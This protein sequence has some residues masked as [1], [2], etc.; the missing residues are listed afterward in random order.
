M[1][2]LRQSPGLLSR[3]PLSAQV[4]SEIIRRIFTGQYT[5]GSQLPTENQLARDL[6]VSRS[7]VRSAY[8]YLRARGIITVRHGIG[9]FVLKMPSLANP[10]EQNIEIPEV[11]SALGY[12]IG[13]YQRKAEIISANQE[14]SNLLE[15]ESGSEVLEVYKVFT[16][17]EVPIILYINH[18]PAWIFQDRTRMQEACEP[19]LTEPPDLFLFNFCEIRMKYFNSTIHPEIYCNVEQL[20]FFGY[21]NPNEPIL[22]VDDIGFDDLGRKVFHSV[23]YLTRIAA[24][25]DVN[26]SIISPITR[27]N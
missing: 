9:A 15:I 25:F 23:E 2:D 14:L 24:R 4:E 5:P 19:T 6:G 18:F 20:R 3:Q 26:R 7:T 11:I 21:E 22:I 27:Q 8:S 10:Y 13:F 12:Q 1:N 16:A 17:D